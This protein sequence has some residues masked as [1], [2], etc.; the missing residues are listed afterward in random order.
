MTTLSEAFI[1]G[2]ILGSIVTNIGW[3]YAMLMVQKGNEG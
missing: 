3:L 2:L 1:G